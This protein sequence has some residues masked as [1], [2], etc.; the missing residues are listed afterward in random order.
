MNQL[1][2]PEYEESMLAFEPATG[3]IIWKLGFSDLN[4]FAMESPYDGTIVVAGSNKTK[5]IHPKTGEYLWTS[6]D[7]IGFEF[8]IDKNGIM[9]YFVSHFV[10]N[11][12]W[13]WIQSIG[14]KCI[15]WRK[16]MDDRNSSII[17]SMV[18]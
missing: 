6:D 8:S 12:I 9:Q 14:H 15:Q 5:G 7:L 18:S 11:N 1:S 17:R 13:S 16:N 4:I 10:R 3:D 2:L